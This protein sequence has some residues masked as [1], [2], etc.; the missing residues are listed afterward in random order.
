[1]QIGPYR[2][3]NSM[4]LAPMA[5]LSDVPFRTLVWRLG[6]GYMVSEMLSSKP[7]LWE[8]GKSRL[9]RVPVPGVDP[10]PVVP[11]STIEG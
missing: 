11:G 4:A 1:M 6:A 10:V 9:R 2:L 8:S 7:E 5:G 3:R